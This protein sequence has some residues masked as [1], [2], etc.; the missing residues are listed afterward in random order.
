MR[1]CILILLITI[2]IYH[3]IGAQNQF[4]KNTH[5]KEVIFLLEDCFACPALLAEARGYEPRLL[6]ADT[7][8]LRPKYNEV[9]MSGY[10]SYQYEIFKKENISFLYSY[11]ID[12]LF[13]K[14]KSVKNEIVFYSRNLKNKVNKHHKRD[15]VEF[16]EPFDGKIYYYLYRA[17]IT[18]FYSGNEDI[19]V[20]YHSGRYGLAELIK[21]NVNI[22]INITDIVP[23]D[24]KSKFKIRNIP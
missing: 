5:T 2:A 22:I 13:L 24:V 19:T 16:R 21:S 14:S 4:S 3:V 9:F 20:Y 12:S 6:L 8:I 11:Q 18:Y 23:L 17:K 7:S 10:R 1:K 15:K